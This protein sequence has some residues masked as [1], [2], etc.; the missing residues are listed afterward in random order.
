[1]KRESNFT[2]ALSVFL[3]QLLEAKELLFSDGELDDEL[4]VLGSQLVFQLSQLVDGIELLLTAAGS[5]VAVEFPAML[6]R[7]FSAGLF[8]VPFAFA[9][10]WTDREF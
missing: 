4:I 2:A 3:G 9:G 7:P 6:N 10:C 1:M 8:R 5:G